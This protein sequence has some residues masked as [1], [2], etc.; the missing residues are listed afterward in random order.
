MY[1]LKRV[2]QIFASIAALSLILFYLLHAMPG[3]PSDQILLLRGD[4]MS[5]S[6][7]QEFRRAHFLDRPTHKR[8]LCWLLGNST[9]SCEAWPTK[10]VF[11]GDL[12]ISRAHQVPVSEIFFDRLVLSLGLMIPAFFLALLFSI[13]AGVWAAYR[14]DE[15]FDR[16]ILG[17]SF[18]GIAFPIH[19]WGLLLLL[20]FAVFLG[21]FPVGGAND[22]R[23]ASIFAGIHHAI[24]P[25]CVLSFFYFSRWVRHVRNQILEVLP[26]DFVLTAR[27]KGLSQNR[28]LFV[29]VLGGAVLPI[30]TIVGH[31]IPGIF[32]GAVVT[33]RVFSYPGMG[34]LLLE[35]IKTD[36]YFLA[37]TILLVFAV[38][39]F[40]CS[41]LIDVAYQY[42]DPRVRLDKAQ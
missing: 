5:A 29:H 7:I 15:W 16:F 22:I 9:A 31:S 32:A 2:I 33:E 14:K 34:M 38:V 4:Q 26:S 17:L 42:F 27:A 19:C 13:L 11:A 35:S 6:D 41:L 30:L 36:D 18:S 3:D 1:L 12:G 37:M 39:S 21:V 8:Y 20:I 28:I 25:V 10:G 40:T 24:L 23:H